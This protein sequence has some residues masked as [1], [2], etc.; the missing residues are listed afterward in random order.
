MVLASPGVRALPFALLLFVL[1][2]APLPAQP[3]E[4][5]VDR[6]VAVVDD[7]PI[8]ASDVRRL[9]ELGLARP[10]DGE[11]RRPFERRVLDDLIDQRLRL[12]E[13]DRFGTSRVSDEEIERQ[14]ATL[15]ARFGGQ[16]G[17]D[18]R[19][20]ELGL[21]ARGLRHLV[22]QQLRV[23]RY[24]DERLGPRVFVD[25]DDIRA[26]YDGELVP[27]LE[28]RGI[29]LPALDEVREQIRALLRERRLNEEIDAWTQELRL[30]ADVIDAFDRTDE[31]LPP[32]VERY[33]ATP[34]AGA[35]SAA[36]GG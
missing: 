17:L 35:Q 8:L 28:S 10:R 20:A 9:I 13:V 30:A 14:L 7:V 32:L 33:E 4:V 36:G 5:L 11:D 3:S 18:A 12:A 29:P 16:E 23:L 6:I 25:L 19:L 34:S 31:A 24:V 27:E 21:D 2:T 26:Y 1:S 15:R 22:T